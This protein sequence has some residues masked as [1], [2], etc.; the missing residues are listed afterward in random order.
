VKE[1][2][3]GKDVEGL[4]DNNMI[5]LLK[6]CSMLRYPTDEELAPQMVSFGQQTR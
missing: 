5:D 6:A 4:V 1:K 2:S 3:K